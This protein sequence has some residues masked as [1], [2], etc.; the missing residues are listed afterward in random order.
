MNLLNQS[1]L[2][3]ARNTGHLEIIHLPAPTPTELGEYGDFDVT[4]HGSI[5]ILIP[6]SDAALQWCYTHL[7][8]ECD[9]WG[10]QSFVVE[11]RYISDV[12]AGMERDGLVSVDTH[13]EAEKQKQEWWFQQDQDGYC[14]F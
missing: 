12:V 4:N 2:D 3:I 10:K 13:R 11:H 14:D 5:F 6:V 9:R 7:P 8:E 1:L